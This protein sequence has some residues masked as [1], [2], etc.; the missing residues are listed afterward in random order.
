MVDRRLDFVG[1]DGVATITNS[2][3]L[4]IVEP[5]GTDFLEDIFRGRAEDEQVP[6][7]G[8]YGDVNAPVVPAGDDRLPGR[9][10]V[11]VALQ[12][13]ELDARPGK[14][15]PGCLLRHPATH[16]YAAG[17]FD[18]VVNLDG[19]FDP[20]QLFFRDQIRLTAGG[21]SSDSVFIADDGIYPESPLGVGVEFGGEIAVRTRVVAETTAPGIGRSVSAARTRPSMIWAGCKAR[22]ISLEAAEAV[23]LEVQI[24][25]G[26]SVVT[27]DQVNGEVAADPGK[28]DFAL[29][30]GLRRTRP[31]ADPGGLALQEPDADGF[32]SIV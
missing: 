22:V 3:G 9:E 4:I 5:V 19:S 15:T 25:L 18:V 30:I 23:G 14:G 2:A 16:Q 10:H 26:E 7:A 6:L 11:I 21:K 27:D 13:D 8:R 20:H 31:G 12:G 24:L 28:H 32:P 17:K 1:D 29:V